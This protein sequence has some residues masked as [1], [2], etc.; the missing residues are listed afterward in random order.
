MARKGAMSRCRS[1]TGESGA[2]FQLIEQMY[3]AMRHP[4]YFVD[5]RFD[6]LRVTALV[7]GHHVIDKSVKCHV[8]LFEVDELLQM[9]QICC[10]NAV[11][12]LAQQTF[13]MGVDIFDVQNGF[14][15]VHG[16]QAACPL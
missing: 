4:I 7:G 8:R 5:A 12:P 14:P 13:G 6:G 11:V 10:P 3:D 1:A 15:F 2:T 9:P 16:L